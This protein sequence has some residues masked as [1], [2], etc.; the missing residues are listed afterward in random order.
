MRSQAAE[1]FLQLDEEVRSTRML[2]EAYAWLEGGTA[3]RAALGEFTAVAA[4]A[5]AASAAWVDASDRHS[6]VTDDPD[7]DPTRL[8]AAE[9][10]YRLAGSGMYAVLGELRAF[11]SRHSDLDQRVQAAWS[12]VA[13]RL[14]DAERALAQARRRVAEVADSGIRSQTLPASLARAEA[15]ARPLASGPHRLGLATALR[16]ADDAASAASA[17]VAAADELES[18]AASTGSRISSTATR[19]DGVVSRLEQVPTTLSRLRRQFSARCSADLDGVPRQAAAA[20]EAARGFLDQARAHAAT[21]HWEAASTALRSARDSVTLADRAVGSVI[22]RARDLEAV[23][24]DPQA[25]QQRTRFAVRDAQR[26]VVSAGDRV[27]GNETRILDSLAERVER[28]EQLL[29]SSHPDYWSYLT[30]LRAIRE[31]AAAV[32]RRAR[33]S[34]AAP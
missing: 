19:L 11:S 4:R 12:Q 9:A 3:G 15:L 34:L 7:A 18:L 5:D 1:H 13:P 17:T 24:A 8:R 29:E 22:D 25:E 27:A 10:D 6:G 28:V 23:V 2:V 21:G 31:V 26:L 20:V 32:V 33:A 30:E 16:A 14:A